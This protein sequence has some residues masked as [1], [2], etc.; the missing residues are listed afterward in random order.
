MS[1]DVSFEIDT[2]CGNVVTVAERNHTSNC[3]GMWAEALD[4]PERP[5]FDADGSP[6]MGYRYDRDSGEWAEERLMNWGLALLHDSPASEAAGVLARAVER[7]ESD[8]D[9]YKQSN[10]ANGWG[11]YESAL[12]FLRW[13]AKTASGHPNSV[14]RISR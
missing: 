14:I 2:G 9:K 3:S 7:M 6:R 8:P 13:V 4:L 12:D 11:D 10:P 1:Y 5:A